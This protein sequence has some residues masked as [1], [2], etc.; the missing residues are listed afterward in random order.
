M[1]LKCVSLTY[2]LKLATAKHNAVAIVINQPVSP[3]GKNTPEDELPPFGDKSI[4][5]YKEIWRT[6]LEKAGESETIC[7]IKA[8]RSRKF[9][10]GKLLFSMK[11]S[12]N[13]VEIKSLV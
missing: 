7:T 11:I 2:Y 3:F 5:G 4:F 1:L 6:Y 9:G 13:G 10:R 12:D 8:W